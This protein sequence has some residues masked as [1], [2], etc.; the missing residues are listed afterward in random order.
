MLLLGVNRGLSHD[1]RL[2]VLSCADPKK[3]KKSGDQPV[4]LELLSEAVPCVA[5]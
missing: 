3:E 5:C 4:D 2:L 1:P